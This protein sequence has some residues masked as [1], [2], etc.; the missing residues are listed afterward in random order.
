[1]SYKLCVR[2]WIEDS[3][4]SAQG[5]LLHESIHFLCRFNSFGRGEFVRCVHHGDG[6]PSD[7]D[8]KSNQLIEN[9]GSMQFRDSEMHLSSVYELLK[10]NTSI[11]YQS[12]L[13]P[14]PPPP[15]SWSNKLR[16]RQGKKKLPAEIYCETRGIIDGSKPPPSVGSRKR[17]RPN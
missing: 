1:M 10:A 6:L 2:T 9:I 12:S 4:L 17:H 8:S 14:Q 7:N 15:G 13:P 11:I 3:S 5:R 16:R